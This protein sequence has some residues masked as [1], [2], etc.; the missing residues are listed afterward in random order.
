MVKKIIFA[1]IAG[2]AAYFLAGIIIKLSLLSA[3]I[4]GVIA[5]VIVFFVAVAKKTDSKTGKM[6]D[7]MTRAQQKISRIRSYLFRLNNDGLRKKGEKMTDL[8]RNVFMLINK[9]IMEA[10]L[11]NEVQIDN[12]F[13]YLDRAGEIL[14]KY[15]EMKQTKISAP[16]LEHTEDIE[17]KIDQLFNFMFDAF[18]EYNNNIK[19]ADAKDL[20]SEIIRMEQTLKLDKFL[21]DKG[22]AAD[23]E[24]LL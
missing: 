24:E 2:I 20:Q 16:D 10:D 18:N 8:A 22:I 13:E 7:K 4:T 1:F 21:S 14:S 15:V 23:D 11:E 12:L 3:V 5:A 6:Q 17:K 19:K 9:K